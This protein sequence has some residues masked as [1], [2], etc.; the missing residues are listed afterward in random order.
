MRR[1]KYALHS[2]SVRPSVLRFFVSVDDSGQLPA[3]ISKTDD[4]MAGCIH[5]F[6]YIS[7]LVF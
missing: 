6:I 5:S 7:G 1:A 2:F 4:C 3:V